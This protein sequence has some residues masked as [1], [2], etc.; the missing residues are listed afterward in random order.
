VGRQTD[1]HQRNV[2]V[3]V[4]GVLAAVG[5]G[6]GVAWYLAVRTY[7]NAGLPF[8]PVYAFAGGLGLG[9]LMFT[10]LLWGLPFPGLAPLEPTVG[11]EELQKQERRLAQ[12]RRNHLGQMYEGLLAIR[13][14]DV[15]PDNEADHRQRGQ[16]RMDEAVKWVE[17][18]YGSAE[19]ALV[20]DTSGL[21]AP[22]GHANFLLQ[23]DRLLSNLRKLMERER[24]TRPTRRPLRRRR[25]RQRRVAP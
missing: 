8:W 17:G 19:R 14:E 13:N 20:A 6:G 5:G 21:P 12:D 24:G 16:E 4:A 2:W 1:E 9:L 11:P 22:A 18:K 10:S 23:M 7:P 25:H 3:A 15:A